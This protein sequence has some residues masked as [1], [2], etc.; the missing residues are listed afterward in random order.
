MRERRLQ[1][2]QGEAVEAEALAE[3]AVVLP[4]AVAHVADQRM[5][6]VLEVTP[7]LVPAAGLRTRFHQGVAL[8]DRETAEG[9]DGGDPRPSLVAGDGMVDHPPFRRDAAHQRQVALPDRARREALLHAARGFDVEG[10]EEDAAGRAVE[11]VDGV[12]VPVDL[13]SYDLQGESPIPRRSPVHGEP[14]GLGDRDQPGVLIE[15]GEGGSRLWH[16]GCDALW[17]F[18]K[19]V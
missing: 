9:G 6:Q 16:R 3:E 1:G 12:D 19:A 13:I 5:A 14:G 18:G 2:V 4:L 15:D 17:R 8:E 10:E 7:D 11:A